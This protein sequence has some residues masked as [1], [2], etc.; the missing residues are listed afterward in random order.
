MSFTATITETIEIGGLQITQANSY[1]DSA[2]TR[3]D[4]AVTD[5]QTDIPIALVQDVSE[6]AIVYIVSDQAVTLEF[7]NSTTGVP[8]IVL[9]AGVP[10]VWH[11]N[12]YFTDLLATDITALFV[13]NA[14][15]STA[16]VKVR[17]LYDST[18]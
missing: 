7:N 4:E 17:F 2:E 11:T 10:Y 14:S 16:N 8:E 13:T 9:L 3:I 1:T 18:P 12:S 5:S 6:T 15:G